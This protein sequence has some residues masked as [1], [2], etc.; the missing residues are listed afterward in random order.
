MGRLDSTKYLSI[1]AHMT[2][3]DI[4]LIIIFLGLIIHG[5]I[6][7]LIR[8]LFDIIALIVG[9]VAAILFSDIL[10]LPRFLSFLIIFVVAVV[11]VVLLGRLLSKLVHITPL[12][13]LDRILGAFLGAVKG[14]AL[15]FI[16]LLILTLTKAASRTLYRSSIASEVIKYGLVFSRA[17]PDAWYNWVEDV[18]TTR[19]IVLHE[20]DH[21]VYL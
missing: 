7:G 6:I 20:T 21:H 12:G 19:E 9:Y 1:I 16:F 10:P 3:I 17:L 13:L 15:C 5:I 2:W 18:A 14:F 11:I 8:G 4:V